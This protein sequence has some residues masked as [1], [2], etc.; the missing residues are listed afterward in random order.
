MFAAKRKK[1]SSSSNYFEAEMITR[2]PLERTSKKRTVEIHGKSTIEQR[3]LLQLVISG[4][5]NHFLRSRC[6]LYSKFI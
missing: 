6:E 5:K 3:L 2:N 4:K 1:T